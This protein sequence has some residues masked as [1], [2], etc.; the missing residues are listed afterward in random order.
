MAD[1][2]VF[3]ITGDDTLT[4]YGRVILNLAEGDVSTLTFPEELVKAKTGKNGNTIFAKNEAG[5]NATLALRL[6]RGSADDQFLNNILVGTNT[7]FASTV[8]AFGSFVKL[9]GDGTGTVVNDYATLTAGIM[10]RNIDTKSNVDGDVAQG[11]AIYNLKF[12]KALRSIK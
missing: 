6:M 8:L 11:V 5:N 2:E 3:V 12:A 4:L 10:T 7:D 9:L 1:T